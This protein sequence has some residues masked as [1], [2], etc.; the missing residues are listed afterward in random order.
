MTLAFC[1]E[2]QQQ[3]EK[4]HSYDRKIY[5]TRG[6]QTQLS[7]YYESLILLRIFHSFK[8]R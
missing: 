4:N 6:Q 8:K 2:S 1:V 3:Q 7:T 5:A